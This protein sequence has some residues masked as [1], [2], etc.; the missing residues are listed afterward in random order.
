MSENRE[1]E[2]SPEKVSEGHEKI[3]EVFRE[4]GLTI[5]E[6]IVLYGN[7]GYTLGASIAGYEEK[8]PSPEELEKM[9]YEG[10]G[11]KRKQL[12]VAL[13][14]QGMLCTSWYDSWKNVL[15]NEDIKE[16]TK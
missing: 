13:M 12:G 16:K 4:L 11:S 15:L 8:G 2:F 7:L 6:I 9:Y 14:Q 3:V 1:I 5:G 10:N